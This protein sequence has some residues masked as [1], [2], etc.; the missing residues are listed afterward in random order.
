MA[1]MQLVDSKAKF[2]GQFC[3]GVAFDAFHLSLHGTLTL[4]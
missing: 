2:G 3:V 1:Q 4:T